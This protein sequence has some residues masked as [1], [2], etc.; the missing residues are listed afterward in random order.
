MNVADS[1]KSCT[2]DGKWEAPIA[3]AIGHHLLNA[4]TGA[5]NM[6]TIHLS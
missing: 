1:R 6:M 3:R 5:L 4:I 2:T